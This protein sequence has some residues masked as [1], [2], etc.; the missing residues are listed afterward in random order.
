MATACFVSCVAAG[1][2]CCGNGNEATT[3]NGAMASQ[4][5][6]IRNLCNGGAKSLLL[7]GGSPE[8]RAEV[9]VDI[10][11]AVAYRDPNHSVCVVFF[12]R[13]DRAAGQTVAVVVQ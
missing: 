3:A 2:G 13:M 12:T 11:S 6:S 4:P 9:G 10:T 1:K 5:V 8:H 7:P